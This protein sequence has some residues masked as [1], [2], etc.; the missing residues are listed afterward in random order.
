MTLALCSGR[1]YSRAASM[2]RFLR[3]TQ[4]FYPAT[5]LDS[6][7]RT[8]RRRPDPQARVLALLTE[9]TPQPWDLTTFLQRLS[10]RL[11]RRI[12][13]E[14]ADMTPEMTGVWMSTVTTDYIFVTSNADCTRRITIVAHEIAHIL[15]GHRQSTD[16]GSRIGQLGFA[17]GPEQE[18]ELIATVFVSRLDLDG[19]ALGAS[20]TG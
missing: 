20:A 1:A 17:A 8:S 15:L 11:D 19:R 13:V 2:T 14:T 4:S 5:A 7:P 18:A 16:P 3:I 12:V 10:A 6:W 9:V